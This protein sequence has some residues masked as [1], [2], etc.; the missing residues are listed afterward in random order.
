M[1]EAPA[2]IALFPPI[3]PHV[4]L[5]TRSASS[6]E[7]LQAAVEVVLDPPPTSPL[8]LTYTLR[9]DD[10]PAT[11]DADSADFGGTLRDTLHIAAG[12]SRAT[13]EVAVNDDDEIEP[14]REWSILSLQE[15]AEETGYALA[16]PR[17]AVI[18]IEEGV[19]DRTPQVRDALVS[20]T[21]ASLCHR[22][23]FAELE[24]I[25]ALSFRVPRGQGFVAAEAGVGERTRQ[26]WGLETTP[27]RCADMSFLVPKDSDIRATELLGCELDA[28]AT[29]VY[30][31]S[32][33]SFVA[34]PITK[35]RQ[36]DFWGLSSLRILNLANNHLEELPSGLLE[37]LPEVYR[38]TLTR[39]RLRSFPW[40]ELVHMPRM[41]V[42]GLS[43]NPLREVPSRISTY[44]PRLGYLTLQAIQ[45][46]ELPED[47]FAGLELV[48]LSL[49][50]NQLES[51]PANIFSGQSSLRFLDL[52]N[53][54]ELQATELPPD[55]LSP[56]T[57]LEELWLTRSP[58]R[59]LPSLTGLSYL[60]RAFLFG[61]PHMTSLP[62]LAGLT[63]LSWLTAGGP[64][65][66]LS[67]DEFAGLAELRI[68]DL[69]N[70]TGL[71]HLPTGLFFGL[72]KLEHLN[73][74]NSY[75]L[76][77]LPVGVFEGLSQLRELWL[78]QCN[79]E[80]LSEGVFAGL[81]NLESLFLYYNELAELPPRL[82]NGLGNLG[83]L[84]LHDNPG[85]PFP[86][87]LGAMRT[88]SDDLLTPGPARIEIVL[89]EGG[90]FDMRIPLAAHGGGISS[91]AVALRAGSDR[92]SE[93]TVTRTTGNQ[94][95]TQVVL[96]P[97]PAVPKNFTGVELS[98][99]DPLVLFA[100][101]TNH[102]PV[103][104]REIPRL[105]LRAGS[106]AVSIPISHFRDP[107]GDDLEFAAVSSDSDIVSAT[108]SGDGVEV[109]PVS[110]GNARVT[111][112]ATDPGGLSAELSFGIVVRGDYPTGTFDI[113]LV[114]ID[115]VP[116]SL[117]SAFD[118]AV[119]DW[120]AILGPT[121]LPDVPVGTNFQLGCGDIVTDQRVATVDDLV[122]VGS[123][124]EFDG[125][126]G[127]L[128]AA[129]VCAVREVSGLPFM[130]VMVF[131]IADLVALEESGNM[132]EVIL[133]EIGHTLGI[134]S[135][136]SD[137]GL[138][139]NP[140][141]P[142]NQGADTHFPGTHA[143]E[144]F[145]TAGGADYADGE[146]VPVE[147]LAGPGSG[148]SHWREAILDHELLT[149]YLNI[150]V[151]NALS[152]IT[153]QSLTDL[154]YTPDVTLAEPFTLPGPLA[155]DQPDT[156]RKIA[157]GDDILR[158]PIVV[159]DRNGRVVRTIRP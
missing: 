121:E 25:T 157:Y 57:G 97:A 108:V 151:V 126:R 2:P 128:A 20:K 79:L 83:A 135:I 101:T 158:G 34:E 41:L 63:N 45:L 133:H 129:G 37:H 54:Q 73:L 8:T 29:P 124:R 85:A 118:D 82:F 33:D 1:L 143:V 27:I 55:I 39:N 100:E 69:A 51:L 62:S 142:D 7:G 122:I 84:L 154:G 127:I 71:T 116:E 150:G 147:N 46:T 95:A 93:V 132:E 56:L 107:D 70:S 81:D 59:A 90:P 115:D 98:L 76:R 87:S 11:E 136:W 35:L 49:G 155:A 125:P 47:A 60:R 6:P 88:D 38:L 112:T 92:T 53:L 138:L 44:A 17:E 14:P 15:P 109:G 75:S 78:G 52:Q 96:G 141:L 117:A 104:L 74:T 103:P 24:T 86:L 102:A 5:A 13:I 61:H 110:S 137:H 42:L 146:K 22:V 77:T 91:N 131:D 30:M 16:Y 50:L 10:D 66:Q 68:L 99:P 156:A 148:D 123:V 21:G 134:G 119:A 130:G 139:V 152:A 80:E 111:V 149:P 9:P 18:T 36:R 67:G 32:G 120:E 105:R 89:A 31:D 4:A 64:R 48:S 114:L 113:D 26:H 23:G 28:T 72:T 19:C 145:D 140:S 65:L 40:S 153:I 144:A 12:T 159:V 43:F 94:E 58:L 3:G 106:D